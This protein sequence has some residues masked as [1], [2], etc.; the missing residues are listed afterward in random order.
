M[1]NFYSETAIRKGLELTLQKMVEDMDL[2]QDEANKL[3]KYFDESIYKSFEKIKSGSEKK[4]AISGEIHSFKNVE[5]SW[6]F[7]ITNPSL[8]NVKSASGE[9]AQ[10]PRVDY[11]KIVSKDKKSMR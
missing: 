11:L 8:I 5:D 4:V 1:D 6:E 7:I 2:Y 3:L 10:L 9:D